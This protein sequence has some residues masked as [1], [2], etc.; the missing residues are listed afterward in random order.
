M[1]EGGAL[2]ATATVS[3]QDRASVGF[4]DVDEKYRERTFSTHI[5][6]HNRPDYVKLST[7]TQVI[8]VPYFRSI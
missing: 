3:A 7:S 6:E 2:S 8:D 1:W 5:A 4:N